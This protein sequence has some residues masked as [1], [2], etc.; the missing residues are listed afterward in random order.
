MSKVVIKNADEIALMRESGRLLADVF[1][2][3]D[4]FVKEGV[5]DNGNK[6]SR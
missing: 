5:D 3:L 1:A 2:Y 6:R 4:P